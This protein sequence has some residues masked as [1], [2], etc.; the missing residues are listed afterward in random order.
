MSY[1]LYLHEMYKE[2][3]KSPPPEGHVTFVFT[4]IQGSTRWAAAVSLP[5]VCGL[6]IA[7]PSLTPSFAVCGRRWATR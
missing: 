6:A 5:L 7:R 4:D 2:E 1:V 3:Q